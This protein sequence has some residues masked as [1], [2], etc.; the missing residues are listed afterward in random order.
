MKPLVSTF[1]T[2]LIVCASTAAVARPAAPPKSQ[3]AAQR[4]V[5]SPEFQSAVRS[6]DIARM[7][8]L[9]KGTG[10]VADNPVALFFCRP[11]AVPKYANGQWYCVDKGGWVKVHP[12]MYAK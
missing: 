3:A 12:F 7:N 9:L 2:A 6:K 11:P 1:A 10:A 5:A 4:I 8:E